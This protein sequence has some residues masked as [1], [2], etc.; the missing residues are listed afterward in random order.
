MDNNE[1]FLDFANDD[2][3]GRT[4]EMLREGT[5]LSS[6]PS[7]LNYIQAVHDVLSSIHAANKT[8]AKRIEIA[9]EYLSRLKSSVRK[10]SEQLSA[11]EEEKNKAALEEECSST[12]SGK[13]NK[14]K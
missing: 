11:L 6:S 7:P 9:I 5:S 4:I 8:D 14:K 12:A 2:W 10:M 1:I 13:K 3:F